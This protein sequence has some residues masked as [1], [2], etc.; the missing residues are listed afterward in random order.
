[1]QT[2][3]IWW[4]AAQVVVVPLVGALWASMTAR[5]KRLEAK[6]DQVITPDL[7]AAKQ[8]A[9]MAKLDP[10]IQELRRL[11][12]NGLGKLMSRVA[13]LEAHMD[14]LRQSNR[15]RIDVRKE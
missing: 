1:M 11:S 10:I 2:S 15:T 12:D 13:T 3:E 9:T 5:I 14:G 6:L 8:A 7:C 4:E